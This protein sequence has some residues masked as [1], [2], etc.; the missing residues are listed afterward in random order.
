M[1]YTR[2]VGESLT[3]KVNVMSSFVAG[4]VM[5]TFFAPAPKWGHIIA[6]GKDAAGFG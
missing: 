1:M 5:I 4:A 2:I 3:P 6:V